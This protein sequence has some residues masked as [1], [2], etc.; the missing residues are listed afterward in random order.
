MKTLIIVNPK[1]GGGKSA[2]R[3]PLFSK[4]LDF[5]KPFKEIWTQRAGE[6]KDITQ[7]ALKEGIERILV[8]GGDGSLA[9][10]VNGFFEHEKPIQPKAILGTLPLGSGSDFLKTLGVFSPEA[11]IDSLRKNRTLSCDVGEVEYRDKKGKIQKQLFL[12]IA[13]FGCAGE[14][15]N[16]VNQSQKSF[17]ATLTYL[18]AT[19]TTFLSYQNPTVTLEMNGKEKKKIVINNVFICNGKYSGSGMMWGPKAVLTDG[20]F[21]LTLIGDL[22]KLQGI[23]NMQKIYQ[24][25]VL[26][27]AEV[28]RLQCRTLTA[29]SS[30]TVAL[31]VDGDTVGTLPATFSIFPHKLELW[32]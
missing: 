5:L 26:E 2:K 17:G 9:E 18:S 32:Y 16:K 14:I 3:W 25:K 24:G 20:L 30:D 31:E 1:A 28:E 22:P 15:C 13:S 6:T 4:S 19:L 12:N 10:A 23:F 21:D 29:T 8:V 7:H 11:A 27:M